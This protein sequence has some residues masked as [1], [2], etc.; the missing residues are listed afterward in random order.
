MSFRMQFPS[1]LEDVVP[2][3][4]ALLVAVEGVCDNKELHE[5]LLCVL[6]MGN[7]INAGSFAGN[8]C[9]YTVRSSISCGGA[10]MTHAEF[11]R[12]ILF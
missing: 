10:G 6:E 2:A 1:L 7:F 3:I 5:L 8:A 11:G 4:K 12:S 9:G